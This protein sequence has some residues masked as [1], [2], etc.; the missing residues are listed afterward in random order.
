MLRT[1]LLSAALLAAGCNPSIYVRDGVTDGDTFNLAPQALVDDDPVLQ[2]WVAYSL[3][4]SACQLEI[5]DGN[6]ARAT[7]YG[8]ELTARRHLLES[9][10]EHKLDGAYVRDRYL[11]TL[12][13]VRE[14][15]FLEEY[16]VD[17]FADADWQ[18][19]AEVDTEAFREWRRRHLRRHRPET[20][21]IGSWG[22]G[23]TQ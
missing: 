17:F 10:E 19:P 8:C 21:W 12:L 15:G 14:A 5:G 23:H 20:R 2:S 22:Y 13:E 16:T 9:W 1:A 7:S 3:T 4:R 18:V 6:P 11:D